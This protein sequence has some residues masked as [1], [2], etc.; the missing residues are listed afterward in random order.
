MDLK[1]TYNHIAENWHQDHKDDTWW[2]EATDKFIS[3]L[4]SGSTVLDV[5]CGNGSK[6]KY[7]ANKGLKVVGTDFSEKM[8]EISK[9]EVPV[10]DFRVWDIYDIGHFVG[11]FDGVFACAVL[12]H[13]PKNKVATVMAGLVSKIKFGGYLYVAVKEGW[14]GQPEEQVVTEND[15]GFPYER[16]FSFYTV[17]EL[18]KLF[19]DNGL[20]LRYENIA[21]FGKTNWIQIVGQRTDS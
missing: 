3:F 7:L 12:L 16:F 4:E 15:Y 21:T 6:A 18:K 13:V 19:S 2:I 10:G 9:R 17:D 8:I 11:T 1:S 5:G 20:V 14:P